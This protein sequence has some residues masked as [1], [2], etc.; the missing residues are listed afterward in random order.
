MMP[1]LADFRMDSGSGMEWRT[2]AP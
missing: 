2:I 1:S